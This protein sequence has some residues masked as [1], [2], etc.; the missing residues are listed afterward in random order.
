MDYIIPMV[1]SMGYIISMEFYEFYVVVFLYNF[2]NY[3]VTVNVINHCSEF[4]ILPISIAH[5]V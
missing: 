3:R 1:Q 4:G 5:V 2:S